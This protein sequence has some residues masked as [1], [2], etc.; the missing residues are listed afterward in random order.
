M[1]KWIKYLLGFIGMYFIL[2]LFAP[3][4][5]VSDLSEYVQEFYWLEILICELAVFFVYIYFQEINP[6]KHIMIFVEKSVKETVF[7]SLAFSSCILAWFALLMVIVLL[8]SD[9]TF[10]KMVLAVLWLLVLPTLCYLF[11]YRG[12]SIYK[13]KKIRVFNFKVTT[14]QNGVIE[15]VKIDEFGK[16]SKLI[17][18][19][20]GK[21]N[22]FWVSSKSAQKY[23]S[24]LQKATTVE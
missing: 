24:K 16:T 7:K 3:L 13:N 12:I 17:V 11:F 19:I 4:S 10:V 6:R 1:K 14:Y 22:V 20:N 9:N 15:G 2:Y 8:V 23:M 5:G 21:E 18:S